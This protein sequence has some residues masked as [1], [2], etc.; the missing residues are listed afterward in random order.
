M[1][2]KTSSGI[3]SNLIS[4]GKKR[5][6]EEEEKEERGPWLEKKKRR[7]PSSLRPKDK[8]LADQ[9]TAQTAATKKGKKKETLVTPPTKTPLSS[10]PPLSLLHEKC[11]PSRFPTK[12]CCLY[13]YLG[14]GGI[15]RGGDFPEKQGGQ[16][17]AEP[18]LYSFVS[19]CSSASS[20]VES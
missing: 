9:L 7:S 14:Q 16:E 10:P 3:F 15:D 4:P 13:L 17:N 1:R 12:L 5:K 11:Q 2:N 6:K 18:V 19:S 20:L 8:F